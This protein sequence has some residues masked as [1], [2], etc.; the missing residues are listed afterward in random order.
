[1][2]PPFR[3]PRHSSR[4][5]RWLAQWLLRPHLPHG[6][7]I[8]RFHRCL[9]SRGFVPSWRVIPIQMRAPFRCRR[10]FGRPTINIPPEWVET[11]GRLLERKSI[12]RHEFVGQLP[13]SPLR[14]PLM[15][16]IGCLIFSALPKFLVQWRPLRLAR[17]GF[18]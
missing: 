18:L 4:N 15:E 17:L 10:F 6:E 3:Y 12:G 9:F 14:H 5:L 11:R 1:M 7:L 13:M 16:C 2:P 8:P